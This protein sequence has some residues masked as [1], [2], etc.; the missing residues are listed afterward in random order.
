MKNKI[1]KIIISSI[2]MCSIFLFNLSNVDAATLNKDV[3]DLYGLSD[4]YTKYL[5]MPSNF[6]SEEQIILNDAVG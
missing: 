5:E 1:Q 4:D 6:K 2:I 3:I